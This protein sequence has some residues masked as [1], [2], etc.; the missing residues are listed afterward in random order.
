MSASKADF[1][2][3]E[4]VLTEGVTPTQT[5]RGG[6]L[7]L[8]TQFLPWH[9]P[10]K[11]WLRKN[12]WNESIRA[13]AAQ[14]GLRQS[15]RPLDYLCLPG[16]DLLDIRALS[17]ICEQMGVNLR[18]LGLNYVDPDD[19]TAAQLVIEQATSLSEVHGMQNIDNASIVLPERFESIAHEDSVTYDKIINSRDTFDVVNIDL[20]RSFGE[21][22]PSD[23]DATLYDALFRL[24]HKQATCRTDDWLFFLTTRNNTKMV[25]DDVWNKLIALINRKRHADPAFSELLENQGIVEASSIVNDEIVKE[26]LSRDSFVG[27]FGIGVG[28]WIVECLMTATPGWKA[29]MLPSYGYH[30]HMRADDPNCDM[31][32]LAFRCSRIRYPAQDPYGLAHRTIGAEEPNIDAH[33]KQCETVVLK[34]HSAQTDLDLWLNQRPAEHAEALEGAVD[35]LRAARYDVEEYRKFADMSFKKLDRYLR[36]SGLLSSQAVPE[37]R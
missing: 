26:K 12:Q 4:G 33:R 14:L 25:H 15:Q 28:L 27:I 16:Q 11:H 7:T 30:I 29:E 31:I 18:F 35:L 23:V 5:E 13:L 19:P 17:P 34:E 8:K 6:N 3:D 10:R 9:K 22:A 37:T 32:S 36:E 1:S 24:F 20:C 21:G 2:S